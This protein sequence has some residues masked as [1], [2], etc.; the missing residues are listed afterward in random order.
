MEEKTKLENLRIYSKSIEWIRIKA[1][2]ETKFN[3]YSA[4]IENDTRE[5]T[6]LEYTVHDQKEDKI[7][8]Y[9]DV[10]KMIQDEDWVLFKEEIEYDLWILKPHKFEVFDW[11]GRSMDT[12]V[13]SHMDMIR[14]RRQYYWNL[15]QLV[16]IIIEIKMPKKEVEMI[17]NPLERGFSN[18]V[19]EYKAPEFDS[20][21]PEDIIQPQSWATL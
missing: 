20:V 4:M 10:L 15:S 2:C 14:M 11:Y 8:V 9:E 7:E 16:D 3:E 6:V 21:L 18:E 1:Y 5:Y 17:M 13:F 12:N 19:E